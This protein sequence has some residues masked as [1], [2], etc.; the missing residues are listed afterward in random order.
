MNVRWY[1]PFATGGLIN[2][3]NHAGIETFRGNPIESLAREINQNSL[4]AV[5]DPEKPVVVE[6]QT[7]EVDKNRFPG[8]DEFTATL[9]KCLATW[10]GKNPKSEEFLLNALD[11]LEKDTIQFL[12]I[13]DFNT[14]GL[15]GAKTGEIGSPW[16]SLVRE[17]GSSNKAEDSGGS[18]GIGK[19]APFLV[20]Q[21]RTLFYSSFD[22][23]GYESHIGVANLMSY[24]IDASTFTV[25]TGYYTH[26]ENSSAIPGQI[27]LDKHFIRNETGTDIYVSAFYPDEDWEQEMIASILYNFFITIHEKKLIVKINGFE[28]NH[29]NIGTLIEELEDTE[30]NRNLKNYFNLLTSEKTL[31]LP[32]PA[33]NYKNQIIFDEGEAI[34]YLLNGEDLNRR[35]LMTRKNG[36]RIYEQGHISGSISFTGILRITGKNMN[37]IFKEMENPEHNQ[38]SPNRYEKDP[39]LADRIFRELRRFIRETVKDYFQEKIEDSM[40]AVGLSDF[41]PNTAFITDGEKERR[42]SITS[43]IKEITKKE[44]RYEQKK[45]VHPPGSIEEEILKQ[46]KGDFGTS[47][48][49][50]LTGNVSDNET[51]GGTHG[52]GATQPG[53]SNILDP[54]T[55][56]SVQ[57][58]K[59]RKPSSKPLEIQYRYICTNKDEG[60][61]RIMIQAEKPLTR[62]RLK[63]MTY[64]EQRDLPLHVRDAMTGD[65]EVMIEKIEEDTIYLQTANE[66]K[67]FSLDIA[68]DYTEYCVVGALLYEN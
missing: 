53:G 45:I 12:R 51:S 65:P 22:R 47:F 1:F 24:Q 32:Y 6:F 16:S 9:E 67:K 14:K 17:A 2:S 68:I 18:F 33:K 37:N 7:F 52:G 4:D 41:L 19:S 13:S 48:G 21:F 62:A 57:N 28:I 63:L 26:D 40:D 5:K 31:K 27:V 54:Y 11:I 20:S 56:G 10:K 23:T 44:K 61:Y 15:E 50:D 34:L 64:G 60:M 38:W 66:R 8:L 46:L 3:I 59:E 39:K 42:E 49:G 29:Q 36:M 55:D 30:E 43:S 58:K 35:V 25:G